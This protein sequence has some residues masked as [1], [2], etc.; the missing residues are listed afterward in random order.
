MTQEKPNIPSDSDIVSERKKYIRKLVIKPTPFEE[1]RI[2]VAFE[3]A[4][5]W[6]RTMQDKT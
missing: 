3:Y 1:F 5:K 4:A 2:T 6:V